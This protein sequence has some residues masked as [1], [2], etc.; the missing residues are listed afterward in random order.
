ME[1]N[2]RAI[3]YKLCSELEIELEAKG[4][5]ATFGISNVLSLKASCGSNGNGL[6][7]FVL[8]CA[9]HLSILIHL[10]LSRHVVAELVIYTQSGFHS[11]CFPIQSEL[12][13]DSVDWGG[14]VVEVKEELAKA[15]IALFGVRLVLETNVAPVSRFDIDAEIVFR[16]LV[17]LFLWFED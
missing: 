8:N 4:E 9:I 12:S 10:H 6:A 5:G 15:D 11:L 1:R 2:Q 17:F 13:S 14:C 16:E 7:D 3:Y